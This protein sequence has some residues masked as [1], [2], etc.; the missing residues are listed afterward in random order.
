MFEFIRNHQ[1]LMQFILLVLIVPPFALFGID[2]YTRFSDDGSAVAKVGGAKVTQQEFAQAQREQIERARQMLGNNFDPALL[3]NPE[4]RESVLDSVVNQRTLAYYAVRKNLL[5]SNDQLRATIQS[6]PAVQE[7]GQFNRERYVT[8]LAG[9]GMTPVTFEDKLRQ[10]LSVQ[11]ILGAVSQSAF[12]PKK[13]ID[14]IT[15]AQLEERSVQEML[16][17]TAA[18]VSQVKLTPQAIE[19]YYKANQK[20]FTVPTQVKVE[21]LVLSVDTLAAGITPNAEEVKGFYEQNK[22]RYGQ[23][24]ERQAS[25]ILLKTEGEKDK[26]A[27]KA[28]AESV[29]KEA[30]AA[31]ADF[32]A[33]AKKYSQDP[34]SAVQGGDLGFFGKGAMVKAFED[35][36]FAMKEG[37]ISNLVE[38]EFGFHIIKLM[39]VK[40]AKVKP[41]EEVRAQIEKEFRAQQAQKKFSES[42]EGFTNTVYE[43]ADSLKPAADK[44]KLEIKTSPLFSRATAPKEFGNAKLLDRLFGDDALKTKRNTE[45]IDLGKNTLISA[46]V[47]EHK[48]QSV[49]PL[50]EARPNITALLTAK[51]ALALARKDGEAKLKVAQASADAAGFSPEK[52]VSRVK[53]EGLSIE[54]LRAVLSAPTAKLPHVVGVEVPGGY[55]VFRINKVTAPAAP[56]VAVREN[57]KASLARAQG[58]ADFGGTLAGFKQFAKVET[59]KQNLDKKPQ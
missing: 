16:V 49:R 40:A 22:G 42:A 17:P 38:S 6:I 4:A 30:K 8:L 28:K 5:V 27:I 20:D 1:R 36:T 14:F 13:M 57:L 18:F 44:Y 10:D 3:D 59:F 24:E 29:L 55:A 2:G 12:S 15:R 33:L 21:Y 52:S 37:E 48:P 11:N 39:G 41:F 46:R 25:H 31:G 32:A 51:E 34:G 9:Q 47:V 7:N 23:T 19:E 54:A 45:A 35:A 43:Q 56:D 26:A 53:P 50:E 58:E